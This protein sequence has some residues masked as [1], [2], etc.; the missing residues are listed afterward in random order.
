VHCALGIA[1]LS[2]LLLFH[3]NKTATTN[4]TTANIRTSVA[5]ESHSAVKV[6]DM[7]PDTVA[8]ANVIPSRMFTIP[9]ST[10]VD[11]AALEVAITLTILVAMA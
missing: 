5:S 2:L 6:P 8:I 1:A 11:V 4:K 3:P 9:F 7:A 10:F